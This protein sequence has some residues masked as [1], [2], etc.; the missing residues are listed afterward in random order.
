[1]KE[2]MHRGNTWKGENKMLNS[3]V[4]EINTDVCP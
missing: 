3:F 4:N 2:A 1:M